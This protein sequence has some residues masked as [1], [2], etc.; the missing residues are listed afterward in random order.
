[1]T[2]QMSNLGPSVKRSRAIDRILHSRGET[3]RRAAATTTGVQDP[4][5][6]Q[7][8]TTTGG[9]PQASFAIVSATGEMHGF[10]FFNIDN[11]KFTPGRG[12]EY[13]TFDH[14]GKVVVMTGSNLKPVFLAIIQQTLVELVENTTSNPTAQDETVVTR[15]SITNLNSE[16]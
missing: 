8:V 3:P 11:L 10:H 15:L 5:T 9:A 14:R 1:M 6:C 2:T 16:S 7:S 13:L 12:C 4:Q